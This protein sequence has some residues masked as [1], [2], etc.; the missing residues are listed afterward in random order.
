VRPENWG[1]V[2]TQLFGNDPGDQQ[3]AFAS[4]LFAHRVNV[5]S[6]GPGTGKT[7]TIAKTL[8]ALFT[9]TSRPPSIALVAPTGKAA[10]RLREALTQQ[11]REHNEQLAELVLAHVH[12]T[13]VHS[14]L[15]ISPI[16]PRR[17]QRD[18]L[19]IDFLICDE[20]SMVDVSLLAE[21]L[22][23]LSPSTRVVLVG[24]PNQ[25]QSVDVGSALS[26]I[27]GARDVIAVHELETVRRVS[28][29]MNDIDRAL[30]LD[31]YSH[32]RNGRSDDALTALS[33][34][35]GPL[36]FVAVDDEGEG[37]TSETTD[38]VLRR[39]DVL[40][41][42]ANAN[43]SAPERTEALDG[44]MVLAA[45]HHGRLSRTW[46]VENVQRHLG[47]D[48]LN[49]PNR[50]GLPVLITASDVHNGLTNGDVGLV[51][52]G[53]DGLEFRASHVDDDAAERHLP[54]TA[55][56][57]WQPWWAMTIHKSQ[58]SEFDTV[59]VSL[60][61]S[62][63][64]ISRELFYTAVTRA[65]RRVVVIGRPQDIRRAIESPA[66]RSTGLTDAVR[67]AAIQLSN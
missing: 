11:L 50:A 25:L 53:E 41:A 14:L 2:V 3:R 51:V 34:S 12:P 8:L 18:A 66:R 7:F 42:L 65:K 62:T 26:D 45:Q 36:T 64:L 60:T 30:L 61:P 5:L 27:V 58:G 43:A 6:G 10:Q 59:L 46:W 9:A 22:R 31:F 4:D 23:A 21:L 38:L 15:G 55:I 24:D 44:V 57:R 54:P 33:K 52:A 19:A 20:T 56:H 35:A 13:T 40:V 39:A 67:T 1:D 63:R 49:Y 16:S 28:D 17:F 48:L 47:F 29:E 32:V 37:V